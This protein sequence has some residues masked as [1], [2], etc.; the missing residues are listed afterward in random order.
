MKTFGV[1]V[2]HKGGG[3]VY[4]KRQSANSNYSLR[5]AVMRRYPPSRYLISIKEIKLKKNQTYR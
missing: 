1:V 3:V 5:K 2:R 4:N